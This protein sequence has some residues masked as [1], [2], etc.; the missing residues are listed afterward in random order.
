MG[1][2][3]LEYISVMEDC[4]GLAGSVGLRKGKVETKIAKRLTLQRDQSYFEHHFQ[5]QASEEGKLTSTAMIILRDY[6]GLKSRQHQPTRSPRGSLFSVCMSRR[7]AAES[8]VVPLH[9][10]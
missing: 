8:Q 7:K 4:T 3:K 5:V 1:S 10:A 6:L 2:P 9:V